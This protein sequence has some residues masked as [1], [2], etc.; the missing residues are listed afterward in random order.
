MCTIDVTTVLLVDNHGRSSLGR[1]LNVKPDLGLITSTARTFIQEGVTTEYATQVLGTTLDNG[2]L[3]AHLLTKSSRVLY[4]KDTPTRTYNDL[5]NNN[6]KNWNIENNLIHKKNFVKNTDFVSPN[7]VDAYLVF[8]TTKTNIPDPKDNIVAQALTASSEEELLN[9]SPSNNPYQNGKSNLQGNIKVFKISPQMRSLPQENLVN[10]KENEIGSKNI[11]KDGGDFLNPSKVRAL[12]NLPTF[13]VRNEFSPSGY[14]FLG[15]LPNF[16]S[17]TERSKATTAAERKAKFLFRA[18]LM[19]PQSKDF[20]TVTYSGFADFTTTVG[21]TVIIFTPHTSEV[22]KIS[23]GHITKISVEPTIRPTASF[24][25]PIVQPTRKIIQ[26]QKPN[27]ESHK[28][29][30]VIDADD[31]KNRPKEED[32]EEEHEDM[33]AKSAILAH[34]QQATTDQTT[35][36]IETT[37]EEEETT[38]FTSPEA[39]QPS[40][41]QIPMLSTPS[42]EDIAKIVASLQAQAAQQATQPLNTPATIFFDDHVEDSSSD[43]VLGGATTIFFEDDFPLQ[44]SAVE[45]EKPASITT[46][47]STPEVVTEE[48]TQKPTEKVTTT[49][50]QTT[51]TEKQT[52]TTT[53]EAVTEEVKSTLQALE[54]TTE[55]PQEH[56]EE[57]EEEQQETPEECT[58]NSQVVPTT[59]FKTLTYLTTFFIPEDDTTVIS[60]KSNEV[61]STEVEYQTRPCGDD[62]KPTSTVQIESTTKI[63]AQQEQVDEENEE[64]EEEESVV[65]NEQQEQTTVGES[66]TEQH[67]TDSVVQETTPMEIT[68]ERR[69]VT[70]SEPETTEMTTE[71]GDEL[72]LIFKT[73]Y[74]TY[75]YLTT[76]F[77][78]DTSSIA[79][80]IVVTTNVITSTID[81]AASASDPAVAGL[82]TDT[83]F[84]SKPITFEEFEEI[85]PTSIGIGRPTES[86]TPNSENNNPDSALEAYPAEATPALNDE[87][88]LQTQNAVKTYYTTYTYFTT[89]FVDGETE[90]QSRTEVY[91]NYVTPSIQPDVS[92]ENLIPTR[93]PNVEELPQ[94]DDDLF[95]SDQPAEDED[96]EEEIKS[97]INNLVPSKVYNTTINRQK[98]QRPN[99][100]TNE[101]A[102]TSAAGNGPLYVTLQRGTT[103]KLPDDNFLDLSEYETI[104]TMV[105]DVR[106]S[107]SEGDRRIIDNV[108]KRNVLLDDQIV[109]ESNND[110][111]IIPSPTLLLQTSY[112]TFTYF[113]TIYHGT[114]SSDVVSR[115]ET[116]TNVVTETLT[117]TQSLSVENSNLPVTYFTTYT[118]W[119]TLYKDG[120][121][122]VTS[123][124][125]TVSNVVT[126]SVGA[127]TQAPNATIN[128]VEE[129]VDPVISTP[130]EIEPSVSVS[131]IEPSS[132]V[133]SDNLTTYFTT[134]T[135]YTTSY[136]GNSTVLNSRLETVTSI[137]NNSAE[138]DS[139]ADADAPSPV[140]PLTVKPIEDNEIKTTSAP[141]IS[142]SN[143][144]LATGL[145]S[146]VAS[147]EVNSG[148]TTIFS[149]DIF[150]TYIDGLYAKVL[151]STT[152]TVTESIEP[153]KSSEQQNLKPTGVVSINQGSIV[154]ADGV[155]TLFYTTKAIGTYIDNLYAQVIEST[156][157]LNVDLE[158]QSS[159]ATETPSI[160]KTGLVRLI[161]GS[162]VQNDTTTLYQSKVLGTVIDGRY[163]QIIESTSSFIVGKASSINPSSVGDISPTPTQAPDQVISATDTPISPSP[164]VIEGSLS[165]STKTDEEST[166]EENEGEEGEE[167][168]GEGD[169]SDGGR[170]KSRLTFQSRKRTFTPVIRPFVSRPRPTFAP[171]RKKGGPSSATTI[172]R[173]DFTP[174]VTAVP[175]SKPNRFGG[176]RSSAS[177]AISPTASGSRRFSRPKSTSAA[178]GASSSFGRG[179]TSSR[180]QPT[181]SRRGNF[182]TSAAPGIS[183]SSSSRYRVRPTLASNRQPSASAV[184]QPSAGGDDENDLTTQVTENPTE[185]TNEETDTTASLSATTEGTSRRSQNPLLR[186]RR[187]PVGR[188]TPPTRSTTRNGKSTTKNGN[189]PTTTTTAKPKAAYRNSNLQNRSRPNALFPRRNIF[190]TTTTPAPPP[191]EEEELQEEEEIEEEGEEGEDTDYESSDTDSQTENPPESSTQAQRRGFALKPVQIKPFARRVKRQTNYSRFRRPGYRSSS[192]TT[193]P[194]HEEIETEATTRATTRGR[195]TRN[196]NKQATT[197]TT[198]TSPPPK[199][200]SPSKA[201]SQGRSQFTLREKSGNT[202]SNF[203]RPTSGSYRTTTAA[204]PARPKAPRL[205]N[206][207]TEAPSRKSSTKSSS[208]RRGNSRQNSRQSTQRQQQHSREQIDN[209]FVLPDFDGTITVTHTIPT[210]ISIPV[211]NGKVTEYKN[212]VT[213]KYSTEVLGPKQYST[214]LNPYGKEVTVL[215]SESTN[216]GS[217]GETK[218]TQ[219]TLNETPTTS[220]IF[221]PTYIRGRKTSFSHVI[222][223]TVYGVEEVVTTIQPALAAQ[224]P[225]ANILLSQLLLGGLQPQNPLLGLQNPQ[226]PPT[227]TTEFKTRTTT[228]VTTVTSSTSTVIPLTFRG[229]EILTTIVDSSTNVVTATEFLTDTIVVTP[230]VNSNQL[231]SLLVPLLL[232]QQQQQQQQPPTNPLLP[233][234]PAGVYNL[235]GLEHTPLLDAYNLADD[236]DNPASELEEFSGE[237]LISEEVT[238]ATPKRKG[239]KKPR[240]PEPTE[241]PKETSVITLYVSG[242][243][244]NE[245]STV[246]STVIVGEEGNKQKREVTYV[247]VEPSRVAIE[248]ASTTLDYLDTYLAPISKD[249]ASEEL[250]SSFATE[251]LESIIGDVSKHYITK[252]IKASKKYKYIKASDAGLQ[253]PLSGNFLAL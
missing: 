206:T 18:G 4:D 221:T 7:K 239:R 26:P 42:D 218:V 38:Q 154:D 15:D 128:P 51:T 233:Q 127:T 166:T 97:S 109:S 144:L 108:D 216:L 29:T 249:V 163:A 169:D 198:T 193:T 122:K 147:S 205:R 150:G 137:L 156:S 61:V 41:T 19:K 49:E 242:K 70:E 46:H 123:R 136:I 164:V 160:H 213:A 111:E 236:D 52:T 161:E 58:A 6:N 246:L 153:T 60:I 241:P 200:I 129:S 141:A 175:A 43:Q 252:P 88:I 12:D 145:L 67:E 186:F 36:H 47:S 138:I 117:P 17:N 76:Y 112:T 119:T 251:S 115:L 135:Y 2:R 139:D 90:I 183:R 9:S 69:H 118:Y 20:K 33:N 35:P 86:L 84:K 28:S 131:G 211:V 73:L 172:T 188:P 54:I 81:P 199:R 3:Y 194:K 232:Q 95:V 178:G 181:S 208:N 23:P 217:N 77:Q 159:L 243:T 204:T 190:T 50:K 75:T 79:S 174:T 142:D 5:N 134:Y 25:I 158:K 102:T 224:A 182:R 114:T 202:R 91:T 189:R 55:Q 56:E 228:Y 179:R 176:R 106:S 155:S 177:S 184:T 230:T 62:I 222:P 83:Q 130:I 124:E 185:A 48:T 30:M 197:S 110:S 44:T 210:E 13:T 99:L 59:T 113:T 220:V 191:E 170:T 11:I 21:D 71:D 248:T 80:R 214:T 152:L 53:E 247:A 253:K 101:L 126:P 10:N 140:Q 203:K 87:A 74:T 235:G 143:G 171:S 92:L 64:E 94:N 116:V 245:F 215:L 207:Q 219:Y 96:D 98:T 229:K 234:Q 66:T 22:P 231:N 8:P 192:T 57:K 100:D 148:I 82:L 240:R 32:S 227:P 93:I 45:E 149:T 78:D 201:S 195:F 125:E 209:N 212:V 14:S 121:T 132:V 250:D 37:T 196:R 40:E 103:E 146:T 180:I 27:I 173:S 72:E 162:M 63:E 187:P 225:L 107:T 31:R 104:S 238:R 39:I 65:D 165:D 105:T 133:N 167:E 168:E 237:Q 85:A 1:F 157:S 244:P 151:E 226:A 120:S 34:E 16:D 89:I 223:S 68:T 24:K